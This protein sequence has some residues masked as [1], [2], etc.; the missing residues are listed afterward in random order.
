[1]CAVASS[2]VGLCGSVLVW[3]DVL[4]CRIGTSTAS[5]YRHGVEHQNS[6][7][8]SRKPVSRDDKLA[9]VIKLPTGLVERKNLRRLKTKG[10][11]RWW[12][13]RRVPIEQK[14]WFSSTAKL[15]GTLNSRISQL[16]SRC[17]VIVLNEFG[18]RK[19]KMSSL[20]W[21]LKSQKRRR[22]HGREC[23]DCWKALEIFGAKYLRILVYIIKVLSSAISLH[24]LPGR[25]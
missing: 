1:M 19:T 10:R 13:L 21:T 18:E 11:K 2:V 20:Q 4:A 17:C 22:Q 9:G 5:V 24:T 6:A 12:S 16:Y 3:S 15:Y 25:L 23:L 14:T 8:L 7:S